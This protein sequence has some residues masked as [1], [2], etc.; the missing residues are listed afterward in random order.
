MRAFEVQVGAGDSVVVEYP[1]A[2]AT[3]AVEAFNSVLPFTTTV[4]QSEWCGQAVVA[5]VPASSFERAS[6]SDFRAS[7]LYPGWLAWDPASHAMLLSYGKAEYRSASGLRY[8]WMLGDASAMRRS[9]LSELEALHSN[10]QAQLTCRPASQQ[11]PA[12]GK[13]GS[14]IVG[15]GDEEH[16]FKLLDAMAPE[17]V[18]A[19]LGALPLTVTVTTA[20]W[21]GDL[22]HGQAPVTA[23]VGASALEHPAAS[24]YPG[25][26]ALRPI[27]ADHWELVLSYGRAEFRHAEGMAYATPVARSDQSIDSLQR[28]LGAASAKGGCSLQIRLP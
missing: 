21:S 24:L 26:L 23:Q 5:G 7:S 28:W 10:G 2:L 6:G 3:D 9:F 14:L 4:R 25:T 17:T 18:K 15:A 16:A 22:L 19:I 8:A 20:R 27:D 12:G 11:P 1:Q 13:A